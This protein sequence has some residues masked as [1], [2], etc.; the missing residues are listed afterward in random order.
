METIG[1]KRSYAL[2]LCMPNNDD[3]DN[4]EIHDNIVM[5]MSDDD[6]WK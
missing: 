3:D 5:V 6:V 4:Y 1:S 2:T